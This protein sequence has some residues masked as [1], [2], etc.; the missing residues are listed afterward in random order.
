MRKERKDRGKL[1]DQPHN[2]GENWERGQPSGQG[3]ALRLKWTCIGTCVCM[4]AKEREH[5][6]SLE[7][8]TV[9][10]IWAKGWSP[11][12]KPSD[13]LKCGCGG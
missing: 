10:H 1:G 12:Q 3:P 13:R 2:L 9:S 4:C 5:A 6:H 7:R 11:P 8:R